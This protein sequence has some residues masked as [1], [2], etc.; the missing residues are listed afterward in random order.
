VNHFARSFA[1]NE[2]DRIVLYGYDGN[3]RVI[4]LTKHA[5]PV[6][7]INWEESAGARLR[8]QSPAADVLFGERVFDVFFTPGSDGAPIAMITG[9]PI[10]DG[11]STGLSRKEVPPILSE[12][13]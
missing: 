7:T 3:D 1:F 13:A 2:V 9:P 11:L 6:E 5:I 4:N 8:T 10:R 12:L